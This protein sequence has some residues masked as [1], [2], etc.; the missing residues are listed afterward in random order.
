[1]RKACEFV[2]LFLCN[3]SIV[4]KQST[5][6]FILKKNRTFFNES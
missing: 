4:E 5:D 3:T 1:M 6:I 2:A